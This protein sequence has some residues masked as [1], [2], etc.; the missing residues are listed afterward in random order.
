[1]QARKNSNSLEVEAS[2]VRT[3]MSYLVPTRD[4]PYL[5]ISFRNYL[6]GVR[7]DVGIPYSCAT[8]PV[9]PPGSHR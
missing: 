6:V 7:W 4:M 5:S 3:R 9:T 2:F 8:V 1:M